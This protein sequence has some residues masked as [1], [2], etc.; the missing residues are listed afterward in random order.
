MGLSFP[1]SAATPVIT[2][3]KINFT[4]IN[5][6]LIGRQIF[7]NPKNPLYLPQMP[8]NKSIRK[9]MKQKN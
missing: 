8:I 7:S 3:G 6:K 1:V 9:K 2:N 5:P 4:N